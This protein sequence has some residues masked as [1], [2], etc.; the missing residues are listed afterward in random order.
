MK[1]HDLRPAAGAHTKKTRVGRGIANKGESGDVSRIVAL[2]ERR[3]ELLQ[4]V[5]KLKHD[6]NA[7]SQEVSA[8]KRNK[9]AADDLIEKTRVIGQWFICDRSESRHHIDMAD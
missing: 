2:D 9:E 8:R 6:R 1:L 4:R 3:R 7:F 5:E